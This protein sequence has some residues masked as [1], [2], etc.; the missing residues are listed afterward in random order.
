MNIMCLQRFSS[1]FWKEFESYTTAEKVKI[2]AHQVYLKD[3]IKLTLSHCVAEICKDDF[4]DF[5]L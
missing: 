2:A 4:I 1:F 3:F 5:T